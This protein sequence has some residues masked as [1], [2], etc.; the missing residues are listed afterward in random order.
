MKNLNVIDNFLDN[1]RSFADSLHGL[2]FTIPEE[3]F[4]V[5]DSLTN[6]VGYIMPLRLY[7]PIITLIL[8]YWL[9]CIVGY[10]YKGSIRI[11][12]GLGTLVTKLFK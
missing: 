7:T 11:F 3:I 12:S 9:I 5:L 10:V 2:N 1:M 4:A 6:V 8:S